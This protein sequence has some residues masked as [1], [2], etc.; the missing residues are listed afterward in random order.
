MSNNSLASTYSRALGLKLDKPF[1]Y[2]S[3]YS[4]PCDKYIIVNNSSGNPCKNYSYWQEV[5][6]FLKP[7]LI[8]ISIVQLGNSDDPPIEGAIHVQGKTTIHQSSFIIK[9]SILCLSNDSMLAH[10][11]GVLGCPVVVLFGSTAPNCHGPHWKTDNSILIESHRNGKL[12]SFAF[13]ENP[14]TVDMILPEQVSEAVLKI[15]NIKQKEKITSLYIGPKYGQRVI[16]CTVDNL[17]PANFLPETPINIRYDYLE[18]LQGLANQ[19]SVRKGLV[20]T[21]VPID[22]NVLKA[23]KQNIYGV[24]YE[25]TENH[26]SSFAEKVKGLGIEITLFTKMDEEKLNK[27]KLQYFDIGIIAKEKIFRKEDVEKHIEITQN[28]LFKS[29]KILFARGKQ[30]LSKTHF[31]LDCPMQNLQSMEAPII[32]TPKFYEEIEFLYIYNKVV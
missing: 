12:P 3:P 26:D 14:K 11:A 25:I 2:L 20:V 29:R 32:D 24:A 18:N 8:D 10:I 6:D 27:I 22:I 28:S 30:Y 19:L 31:L 1:I 4:L 7:Y 17:L 9:N 21:N 5:L 16:E 15:L 13:N 23:L